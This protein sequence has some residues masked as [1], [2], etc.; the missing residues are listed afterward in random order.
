MTGHGPAD[1]HR[2]DATTARRWVAGVVATALETPDPLAPHGSCIAA[3][4]SSDDDSVES[5]GLERGNSQFTLI[6]DALM[7]VVLAARRFDVVEALDHGPECRFEPGCWIGS[8]RT[9]YQCRHT[10]IRERFR[11]A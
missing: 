5:I 2:A 1:V 7:S 9:R 8:H 6:G 4:L 3:G 10:D 11:T